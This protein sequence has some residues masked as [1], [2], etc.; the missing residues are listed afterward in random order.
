MGITKALADTD[1][2][3]CQPALNPFITK[4]STFVYQ[5]KSYIYGL[6]NFINLNSV[7]NVIH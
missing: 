7:E 1:L 2:Q 3:Q 6:L 5:N 4:I